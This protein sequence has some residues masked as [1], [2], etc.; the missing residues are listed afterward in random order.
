MGS[1]THSGRAQSFLTWGFAFLTLLLLGSC[2]SQVVNSTTLTSNSGT[3]GYSYTQA[4]TNWSP[5]ANLPPTIYTVTN[6]VGI[7]LT[8]IFPTNPPVWLVVT[9]TPA[10]PTTNHVAVTAVLISTN[11]SRQ[12]QLCDCGGNCP[13]EPSEWF[14]AQNAIAFFS[15]MVAAFALYVN[16]R[17]RKETLR[18]KAEESRAAISEKRTLVAV[19]LAASL[20]R[21]D[22]TL[23][24]LHYLRDKL[25]ARVN[26]GGLSSAQQTEADKL[27][28]IFGKRISENDALR[29]KVTQAMDDNNNDQAVRDRSNEDFESTLR[30]RLSS[31]EYQK[32]PGHEFDLLKLG[33]RVDNL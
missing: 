12:K 30:L 21:V 16:N 5:G 28:E 26:K 33:D 24:R 14:T 10:L 25:S 11:V 2:K 27:N 20:G 3:N 8:N 19:A 18:A 4:P 6:P 1:T 9:N 13:K 32:S 17:Q 23:I 31:V 29:E 22:Y 7:T 15:A